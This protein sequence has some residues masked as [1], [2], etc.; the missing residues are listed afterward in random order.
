M[1]ESWNGWPG[2]PQR[3]VRTLGD[4]ALI[5]EGVPPDIWGVTI[6]ADD[7]YGDWTWPG[8]SPDSDSAEVAAARL[9]IRQGDYAAAMALLEAAGARDEA[10]AGA[11]LGDMYRF[12]RLGA[13]DQQAAANWYL[14]AGRHQYGPGIY[15]LA[16]MS[17][18]GWGILFMN[19]LRLPLIVDAAEAGMA[20]ALYLLSGQEN[21]VF[22]TRPPGVTAFDQ[23]KMTAEWGLLAAQLDL[24]ERY[25]RGDGVEPDPMLAY[26][27][28]VAALENTDPGLDNIRSH[29][30]AADLR[31]GLSGAQIAEAKRIAETLVTGPPEGGINLEPVLQGE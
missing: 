3:V 19:S 14:V 6:V 30:L 29:Q 1:L 17:Q 16:T 2:S 15:G 18:E 8:F 11:L 23:V 4:V 20:D 26:A 13:I 25:A 5:I 9:A 31:N 24:A 21:G 28:A 27:W 10:A 12:G 22:Y 7:G